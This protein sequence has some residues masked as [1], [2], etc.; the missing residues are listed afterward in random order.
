MPTPYPRGGADIAHIPDGILSPPVLIG[1]A[2]ATTTLAGIALRRLDF[3]R[4]PQAAVLTA[5]LFVASLITFPAG[6][7]TVHLLLNGLMGVV[8]GWT[9]VPAILIALLLQASFF[10]YGGLLVLGVNT[11]NLALPALVC[12][13][14]FYRPLR[15]IRHPG[16]AWRL[17]AAAG[18]LGVALTALLVALSLGLSDTHLIPALRVL[19]LVYLP[20]LLLEAAVT[21]SILAFLVRVAPELLRGA[22]HD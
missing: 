6:P 7:S 16:H 11:L 4:I 19:V 8:L 12:A 14:L 15:R 17:G 10:G 20:L 5:G 13:M 9:A 18:A 2:L 22:S 1:G 21:G 3:D